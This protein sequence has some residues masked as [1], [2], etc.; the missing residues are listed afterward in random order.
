MDK[1]VNANKKKIVL[2]YRKVMECLE[3]VDFALPGLEIQEEIVRISIPESFSISEQPD[4]TI[5]MLRRL[6]TIGM[7]DHVKKISFDHSECKFLGLSASTIM[8]IILLVILKYREKRGKTLELSGKLPQ[9]PMVKDVLLASGLP[10]H[11]NAR[12]KVVYDSTNV[13]KFETV[14]GECSNDARQSGRIATELTEYFNRCLLHQSM[15]LRDEGIS[16]LVTLLGEVLGNC[17]I[18]G[19]EHA[20]WYTQGHYEDNSNKAYGEMQLL[21][22]NLGNTIYQG[23]KYNSSEETKKRLE[24]YLERHKLSFSEEWNE[25][26][27]CTV[28]AL[29]E[30]ISRLRNRNIKGYECR[31]TG[32]VTLIEALKSI[33][34]SGDGQMPEMTIVSGRT[35]IKFDGRY[36][37]RMETFQNDLVFGNGEKRILAFNQE[38]DIY[39]PA[40]STAVLQ[41]KENFP[42]TVISLR[43][44]L[45]S[46]YIMKA[47]GEGLDE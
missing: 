24:Y 20:T 13:E 1:T 46:R 22:L 6:Y 8:D 3:S 23:L 38:N 10:Y 42:G 33:G 40:D 2:N 25:E 14:S 7:C 29:Q 39:R 26:M 21:F 45:D 34:G 35:Y 47:G 37:M 11:V 15:R 44:Y 4:D 28:F 31:G 43:I 32:T 36:N 9:N 18:H 41:M 17:E 5:C 16:L 19:G 30:G 12:S 27:A